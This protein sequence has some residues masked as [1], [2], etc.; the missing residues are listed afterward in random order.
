MVDNLKILC[1]ISFYFLLIFPGEHKTKISEL[2]LL[3]TK[4]DEAVHNLE[5]KKVSAQSCE[6][7]YMT[8]L[9]LLE[10]QLESSRAAHSQ[11]KEKLKRLSD[12]LQQVRQKHFQLNCWV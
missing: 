8:K 6:E 2:E 12:E 9:Q 11:D 3:L 1:D 10:T 7:T 4:L 5:S